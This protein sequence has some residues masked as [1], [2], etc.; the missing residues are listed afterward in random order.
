MENKLQRTLDA[1]LNRVAEGLRVVE[2][3]FRYGFDH[4]QLQQ[5]LKALRHRLAAHWV[6][7]M[8]ACRDPASDVGF[9]ASGQMEYV[10]KD[11]DDLLGANF[12]RIQQGL[13]CL[14]ELF[15]LKAPQ[16]ALVMKALRYE[17]YDVE[18]AVQLWKQRRPLAPG[19][20]L[21]LSEPPGGY[22]AMTRMAVTAGLPAVQLRYKGSDDRRLLDLAQGMRE[23]TTGSDTRLIINDRPD[24]ALLV[25][26][27]G[28]HVGQGDLPAQQVRTLIGPRRLLGLST[29]TLQQVRQADGLP[30]DYIG[31]G[32]LYGTT[33]KG[34]PDPVLG[35]QR[36]GQAASISP[37]PVV[38]IGG[39]TLERIAGLDLGACRTVAVIGA[40]SAAPDPLAA[41][42]AIQTIF[43]ETP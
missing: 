29:H 2:D 21:V 22:R 39:L 10:R 13:R 5:R 4:P 43:K 17:A 37:F 35:P 30:L 11:V 23:I 42:R 14:E 1:N 40:V 9:P 16:T 25:D 28:V 12:K 19:L 31:F 41:M 34:N 27:D 38:A 26:A 32:P 8:A 20:Y 18:R 24:I 3:L 6:P 36:L 7:S 33:S 15:K